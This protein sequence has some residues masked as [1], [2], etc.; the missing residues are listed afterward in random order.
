MDVNQIN[1]LEGDGHDVLEDT[2]PEFVWRVLRKNPKHIIQDSRNSG[3]YSN[4]A[5]PEIISP[6]ASSKSLGGGGGGGGR[7]G[8]G[9]GGGW[10]G[11]VMWGV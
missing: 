3:L 6:R 2:I 9:W 4:F 5:S 7:G 1:Y 8:G 11:G 10:F